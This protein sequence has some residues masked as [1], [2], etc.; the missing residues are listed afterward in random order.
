MTSAAQRAEEMRLRYLTEA[1]ETSTPASR[2]TMLLDAL[3]MDLARADRAF[4]E[5]CE[6]KAVSDLLIH[7][8]DIILALRDTLDTSTWE[9]AERL[10]AL[11]DHLYTELVGA[12]LDKDRLRAAAVASHV[13]EL[14]NAWRKAAQSVEKTTVAAD[15]VQR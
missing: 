6:P 1:I 8:Q 4:A 15:G 13:A 3:E 10:G 9:P 12:N 7:A 5:R 11:Y 2:L 14:A